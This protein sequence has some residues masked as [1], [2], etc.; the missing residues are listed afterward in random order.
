MLLQ[1]IKKRKSL[2][3]G[4]LHQMIARESGYNPSTVEDILNK[5]SLVM[6][7]VLSQGHSVKLPGF[8]TFR[9]MEHRAVHGGK[10]VKW[11]T[12]VFVPH[13]SLERNV[14]NYSTDFQE[15]TP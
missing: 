2:R 13:R 4:V 1:S 8:G 9:L 15:A 5:T 10:P 3:K 7:D 12:V 6:Y 11:N 14:R